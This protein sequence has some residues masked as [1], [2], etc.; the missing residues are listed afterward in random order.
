MTSFLGRTRRDISDGKR[1]I[2]YRLLALIPTLLLGGCLFLSSGGPTY[3]FLAPDQRSEI[4]IE[5]Y[6]C[7]FADCAIRVVLKH[8]WRY[9]YLANRSDCSLNFAHATW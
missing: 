3:T 1:T 4:R 8:G 9:A 6:D 7:G 5:Q 2:L